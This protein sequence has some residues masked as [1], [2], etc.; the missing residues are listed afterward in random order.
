VEKAI[1]KVSMGS[2]SIWC[3]II[4]TRHDSSPYTMKLSSASLPFGSLQSLQPAV[5][6]IALFWVLTDN[7][8]KVRAFCTCCTVYTAY[9]LWK[10]TTH[11]GQLESQV[12]VT[13][14]WSIKPIGQ[15]AGIHGHLWNSCWFNSPLHPARCYLLWP[16]QI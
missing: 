15:M 2:N 14:R 12:D 4:P 13:K 8:W 3:F 16:T 1:C 9:G 7:V 6:G 11:N 10:H 5:A